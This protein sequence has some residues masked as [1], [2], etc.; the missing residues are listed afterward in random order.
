MRGETMKYAVIIRNSV[1]RG[2]TKMGGIR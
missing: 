2:E 1:K